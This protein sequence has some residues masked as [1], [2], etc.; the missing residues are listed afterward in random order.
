MLRRSLWIGIILGSC[1]SL[2]LAGGFWD[3]VPYTEWSDKQIKKILNDSPWAKKVSMGGAGG[4]GQRQRGGGFSAEGNRGPGFPNPPSGEDT[5]GGGGSGRG[6]SGGGRG[7]PAGGMTLIIRWESARPLKQARLLNS[8]MAKQASPQEIEQYLSR[9]DPNYIVSVSGLPAPML[10]RMDPSR[11][12][13]RAT[14]VRKGHDPIQAQ[15]AQVLAQEA[16]LVLFY[17]PR[18][19]EIVLEDNEVEFVLEMQ[20]GALKK[21][22]RLKDLLFQEELA[23]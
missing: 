12:A 7:G 4:G 6:G 17:F 19:D 16:P 14:L 8:E 23:I 3:T 10:E 5:P 21:K 13:Q 11:S 1:T 18:A 15:S 22:F 2:L 20:R 9:K